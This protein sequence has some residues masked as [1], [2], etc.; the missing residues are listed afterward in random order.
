MTVMD[1]PAFPENSDRVRQKDGNGRRRE[2][3]TAS[4]YEFQ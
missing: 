3:E 4:E 1:P 2:S